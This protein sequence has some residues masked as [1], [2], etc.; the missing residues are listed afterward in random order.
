MASIKNIFGHLAGLVTPKQ[1]P[2]NSST[3]CA[4]PSHSKHLES[5]ETTPNARTAQS[6]NMLSAR[7][8]NPH[9]SSQTPSPLGVKGSKITKTV[10]TPKSSINSAA[11]S[12]ERSVTFQTETPTKSNRSSLLSTLLGF[13]FKTEDS[14]QPKSDHGFEGTTLAESEIAGDSNALYEGDTIAQDDNGNLL[15]MEDEHDFSDFTK[16]EYFLFHKLNARGFE[17]ILPATWRW[18]FRF[19][20]DDLFTTNP[21]KAYLRNTKGGDMGGKLDCSILH[22]TKR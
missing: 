2:K 13:R 17:P 1:K 7:K 21:T 20:P 22:R 18:E 11:K 10:A 4:T 12:S 6:L 15:K 3:S 16:Y 19:L 14:P 9:Q 8:T 5:K